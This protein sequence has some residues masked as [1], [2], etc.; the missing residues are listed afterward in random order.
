MGCQRR[1]WQRGQWPPVGPDAVEEHGEISPVQLRGDL[2]GAVHDGRQRELEENGVGL[3]EVRPQGALPPGAVNDF[4]D[5]GGVAVAGVFQAVAAEL[6]VVH[7]LG[8]PPGAEQQLQGLLEEGD[9][10]LPGVFFGEGLGGQSLYLLEPVLEESVDD[11]RLVGETP[12]GGADPDAG[13][14]RDV[15]ESDAW[16]ALGEPASPAWTPA[17]ACSSTTKTQRRSAR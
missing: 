7:E 15:V 9:E 16:P 4:R 2:A 3:V 8:Q 5:E 13:V 17:Q 12:V 10:C 6:R 14:V 11:L 1:H